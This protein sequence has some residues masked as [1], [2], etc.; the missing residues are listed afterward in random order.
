MAQRKAG[1]ASQVQAWPK[2]TPTQKTAILVAVGT[3]TGWHRDH[4]RKV[5]RHAAAGEPLTKPRAWREPVPR[6]EPGQ[7][8]RTRP[9]PT[10]V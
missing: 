7:F 6:D 9:N 1:L 5:L 3:V 2:A 10:N 4:A 8:H